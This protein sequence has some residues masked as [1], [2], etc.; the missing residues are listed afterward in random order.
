M[1]DREKA[2][3]KTRALQLM[4]LIDQVAPGKSYATIH[5]FADGG[6]AIYVAR[7]DGS[8]TLYTMQ[9]YLRDGKWVDVEEQTNRLLSSESDVEKGGVKSA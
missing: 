5:F 4:R 1:T 6:A 2:V 8:E 3:V 7:K 9:S